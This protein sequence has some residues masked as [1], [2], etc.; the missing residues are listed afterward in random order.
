[1]IVPALVTREMLRRLR[2]KKGLPSE[3]F[4]TVPPTVRSRT[5]T[6]QPMFEFPSYDSLPERMNTND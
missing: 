2:Q 6:E 5:G 3:T 4:E 1:M